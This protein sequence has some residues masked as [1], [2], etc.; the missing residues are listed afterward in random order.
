MLNVPLSLSSTFQIINVVKGSTSLLHY[1]IKTW[2]MTRSLCPHVYSHFHHGTAR[3]TFSHDIWGGQ[4][5][6]V[7]PARLCMQPHGCLVPAE[8]RGEHW[9]LWA[10][11]RALLWVTKWVP[12]TKPE[13]SASLSTTEPTVPRVQ[14]PVIW[15]SV[16][17]G[18]F[19]VIFLLSKIISCYESSELFGS[20]YQSWPDPKT[21]PF[22]SMN[23]HR[24]VH[25]C[26]F[27][28]WTWSVNKVEVH[29]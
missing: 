2:A 16:I 7:L 26:T 6:T 4:W 25:M 12:R 3:A 11:V 21:Q 23:I 8:A 19:V 18:V 17:L 22:R 15:T 24:K 27:L 13:S 5:I 28:L 9:T 29:W 20:I 1:Y 14:N 10:A